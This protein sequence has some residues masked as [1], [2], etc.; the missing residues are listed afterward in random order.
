MTATSTESAITA[1]LAT[2]QEAMLG[3]LEAMVNTDGGSYDKAGV[4]A[5]GAIVQGFMA[6]RDIPVEVVPRE[7]HGDCLKAMVAGDDRLSRGNARE[8]IVLMGHRDTVFPKGEPGRRPFRIE[9]G[10][11]PSAVVEGVLH[12]GRARRPPPHAGPEQ[13]PPRR[14]LCGRRPT[15]RRR[16]RGPHPE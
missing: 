12:L 8:K 6:E 14:A 4:D 5:V 1:W 13:A 9:G 10:I 3:V 16:P 2:Q 7:K 15:S 11:H